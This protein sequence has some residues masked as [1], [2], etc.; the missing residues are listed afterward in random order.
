M[1]GTHARPKRLQPARPA[2]PPAKVPAVELLVKSHQDFLAGYDASLPDGGLFYPTRRKAPRGTPVAVIVRVG[3]RQPPVILQGL[4]AWHRPGKHLQK[5]RAGICVELLPS[6]R[7]K[8][9]YLLDL[10][11]AGDARRSRRRHARMLVELQVTWHP[12]DRLSPQRGTLRDSGPGGAFVVTGD[13]ATHGTD[14]VLE[15]SPPGAQVAMALTARVAWLG[16][17]HGAPGFGVE[18]RARDSGGSRRIREIVRRLT[19]LTES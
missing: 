12:P 7:G 11:R 18:W 8:R 13:P 19:D 4:V 15:V 14:L 9:E 6:E 5:I 10:A 2:A 3:R 16:K 17:L 1:S